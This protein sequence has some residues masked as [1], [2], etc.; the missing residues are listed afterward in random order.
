MILLSDYAYHY[1]P[2]PA[3][4]VIL[5]LNSM[6]HVFLYFYYALTAMDANRVPSWKQRL[7][8]LQILQFVIDIAYAVIGYLHHGFCVYGFIYG[9]IMT[10]LFSNFYYHAYLKPRRKVD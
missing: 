5:G 8:E 1:T 3:I 9:I 4:A 10:S 7:T 2:W 6:V